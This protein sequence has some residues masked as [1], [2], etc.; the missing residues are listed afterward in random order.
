MRQRLKD[1]LSTEK[2]L[3]VSPCTFGTAMVG[4]NVH[5]ETG[6]F[7]GLYHEHPAQLERSTVTMPS[8]VRIRGPELQGSTVTMP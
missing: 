8:R 2:T 5:G 4:P 6:D 7:G 3:F 1:A